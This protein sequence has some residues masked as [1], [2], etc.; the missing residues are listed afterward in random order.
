MMM[1]RRGKRSGRTVS[2]KRRLSCASLLRGHLRISLTSRSLGFD[3]MELGAPWHRDNSQALA[4][5]PLDRNV[6]SARSA[7]GEGWNALDQVAQRDAWTL[8]HGLH[9]GSSFSVELGLLA[10]RRV[11]FSLRSGQ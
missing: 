7:L 9:N 11:G 4:T 5:A 2:S 3:V 10:L 8:S 1:A 6:R